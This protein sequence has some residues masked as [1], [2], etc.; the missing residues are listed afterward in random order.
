[1]RA[2]LEDKYNE[3]KVESIKKKNS[4]EYFYLT[5]Q[6]TFSNKLSIMELL[7]EFLSYL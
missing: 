3:K 2:C 5:T 1:M 6:C 7:M 4:R